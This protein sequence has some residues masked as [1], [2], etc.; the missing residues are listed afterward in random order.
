M[1]NESRKTQDGLKE[2]R[3]RVWWSLYVLEHLLGNM[4]GRATSIS[5]D[6]CTTPLPAPYDE[7][8][9]HTQGAKTLLGTE[10]QRDD[11]NPSTC[12][13]SSSAA[14]S[15]PAS[16]RARS[17]STKLE[18]SKS[19]SAPSFPGL[20]WTRNVAPNASLYFLEYVQLAR[21]TQEI[22]KKLYTPFA[23]HTNW[24]KVQKTIAELDTD[25]GSWYTSLPASFD[26]KKQTRNRDFQEF[27]YN[28]GFFYYSTQMKINRPC[29]CRLDRKIPNQ[30][31]MSKEFNRD[32][33]SKCVDA[34][35]EMLSLIPDEPNAIGLN[36]VG[37]W[38]NILH[39]LVQATTVMMLELS[40]RSTH[41]PGATEDLI[42]SS[43]KAVR[44]LHQMAE[45]NISAQRAWQF[46]DRMLRETVPKVGGDVTD[47]P[48]APARG[49]A[50]SNAPSLHSN[51]SYHSQVKNAYHHQA[52]YANAE[53]LNMFQSMP[54]YNT[55]TMFDQYMP[56]DMPGHN[57]QPTSAEMEFMNNTY[58]E[59]RDYNMNHDFSSGTRPNESSSTYGIQDRHCA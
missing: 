12:P 38:W 48:P 16:D 1:R 51:Q 42:M 46:C 24:S 11:R 53:Q 52:Q 6:C 3:Y 28:L 40:F 39:Y 44:W 49:S 19:P 58:H 13:L 34:A 5:D 37:P 54:D 55:Y 26:F 9:F 23:V 4:T 29:L 22:L 36:S 30:S 41:M 17:A 56:Y 59:Q 45:E 35:Q 8:E 20:S 15:T 14:G 21:L 7:D 25:L 10:V 32:A 18:N 27:R 2:I 47:L 43:K 33:A 50:S 57:Y 31:A